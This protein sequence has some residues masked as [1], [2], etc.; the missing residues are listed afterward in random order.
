MCIRDRINEARQNEENP[1]QVPVYATIVFA[2]FDRLLR[3]AKNIM[4]PGGWT[5]SVCVLRE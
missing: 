3:Y 1:D 2:D 4:V 5:E